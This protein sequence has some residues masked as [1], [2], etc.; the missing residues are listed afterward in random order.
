MPPAPPVH[1]HEQQPCSFSGGRLLTEETG[2]QQR[3]ALGEKISSL[4]AITIIYC[5]KKQKG[6]ASLS[7]IIKHQETRAITI[8]TNLGQLCALET[9]HLCCEL[10]R[11]NGS[12]VRREC[13]QQCWPKASVAS[14]ESH[15]CVNLA[16]STQW[17]KRLRSGK[18]PSRLFI[19]ASTYRADSPERVSAGASVRG[20][21]NHGLCNIQRKNSRPELTSMIQ[22]SMRRHFQASITRLNLLGHTAIPASPPLRMP[23][24]TSINSFCRPVSP[25]KSGFKRERM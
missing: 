10:P 25:D 7:I 5:N 3:A 6:S 13:P 21:L 17:K 18:D 12:S 8:H 9:E 2:G 22:F 24:P 4:S 14:S 11:N 15:P 19:R 23:D 16:R 1:L 20:S